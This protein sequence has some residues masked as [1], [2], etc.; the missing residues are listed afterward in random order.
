MRAKSLL[1]DA[2]CLRKGASA[3]AWHNF[4]LCIPD[5]SLNFNKCLIWWVHKHPQP[6]FCWH[7]LNRSH[8]TESPEEHLRF[9][10]DRLGNVTPKDKSYIHVDTIFTIMS[11]MYLFLIEW[12]LLSVLFVWPIAVQ[13]LKSFPFAMILKSSRSS[14]LKLWSQRKISIFF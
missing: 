7:S 9:T 11:S 13:K 14:Y 6:S 5:K 8:T 12:S 4:C 2:L 1:M 10:A 3:T